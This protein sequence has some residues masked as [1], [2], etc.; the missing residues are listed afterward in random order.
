M[1]YEIIKELNLENGSNYKMN[2]CASIWIMS[3]SNAF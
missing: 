1:V 3:Y 2:V